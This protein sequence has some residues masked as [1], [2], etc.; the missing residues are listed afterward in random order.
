MIHDVRPQFCLLQYCIT[1]IDVSH[2]FCSSFKA[3]EAFVRGNLTRISERCP[4]GSL[5]LNGT[6]SEDSGSITLCCCRSSW[7]R[8]SSQAYFDSPS[9]FEPLLAGCPALVL[10]RPTGHCYY[11]STSNFFYRSRG[12]AIS[13][14]IQTYPIRC[15]N[16]SKTDMILY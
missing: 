4:I 12:S 9:Y 11:S 10:Y 2:A 13:R 8:I 6:R 7:S 15:P 16:R 5:D 1:H 3:L 14:Q